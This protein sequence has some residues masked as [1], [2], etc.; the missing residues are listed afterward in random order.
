MD[1]CIL[2]R[3]VFF[4]L[5]KF[6]PTIAEKIDRENPTASLRI[7]LAGLGIGDGFM[8]PPDTAVHADYLFQVS[9][10]FFHHDIY[11]NIEAILDNLCIFMY[12]TINT[13]IHE[14]DPGTSVSDHHYFTACTYCPLV[15]ITVR[16]KFMKCRVFM[17]LY[18]LA[19]SSWW[20]SERW[21]EK[22]WKSDKG[23]CCRWKL[24]SSIFGKSSSRNLGQVSHKFKPE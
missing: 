22:H 2:A 24:E 19:L 21:F 17:Y 16:C 18:I 1:H 13:L 6:V 14:A 5:G 12:S 20:D 7:N 8:S 10:L 4:I 3:F 9:K 23:R 15:R 11:V